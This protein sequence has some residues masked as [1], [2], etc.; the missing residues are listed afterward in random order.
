VRGGAIVLAEGK[1]SSPII[2]VREASKGRS[3]AIA[4]DSLWKWAFEGDGD[5]QYRAFWKNAI[6]WL[7]K[8][9]S[10]ERT[11]IVLEK[12]SYQKDEPIA[13]EIY[14]ND[15]FYKPVKGGQIQIELNTP[16]KGAIIVKAEERKD[17]R[18]EVASGKAHITGQR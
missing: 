14:A 7:V 18:Y 1:N 6:S 2:S 16:S 17:G 10:L 13:L 3:L 9:P 8:E 12:D 4:T 15:Q 5:R 11:R